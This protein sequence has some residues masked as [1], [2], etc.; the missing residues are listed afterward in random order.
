[1]GLLTRQSAREDWA[2]RGGAIVSISALHVIAIAGLLHVKYVERPEP[3]VTAI[4]V[5]NLTVQQRVDEP[6]PD[7][8]VVLAEPPPM[9]IV[10]PLVH[11]TLETPPPTAITP[12]P[13]PRPASAPDLVV[14][15]AGPV[16]LDYSEVDMVKSPPPVYP[17]AAKLAGVEGTVLVWALVDTEGRPKEVRVHR[18]SGFEQLDRAGCEG[19]RNWVFQ[20]HKP[21]GV[22]KNVHVIIPVT[23]EISR[24]VARNDRKPPGRSE[25]I[26]GHRR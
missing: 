8:P 14:Q 11:I 17:R 6:A 20:P 18:S 3:A 16:T 4:Q 1:M 5:T 22:A 2:R 12:P 24:R 23:F 21:H 10:V 26:E 25:D 9:E 19:V 13:P 15:D 7:I